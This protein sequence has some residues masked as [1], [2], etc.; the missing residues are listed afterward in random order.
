MCQSKKPVPPLLL[1][2][3]LELRRTGTKSSCGTIRAANQ[4]AHGQ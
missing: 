4:L 2:S 3:Q 1:Q